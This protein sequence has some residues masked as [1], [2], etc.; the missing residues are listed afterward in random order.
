MPTF[1][2]TTQS[3]HGFTWKSLLQIREDPATSQEQ[4]TLLDEDRSNNI[5]TSL[6]HRNHQS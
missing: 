5:V 6:A 4:C 3:W 2:S 1:H